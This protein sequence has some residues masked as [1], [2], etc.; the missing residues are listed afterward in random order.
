MV[1]VGGV[2]GGGWRG[3]RVVVEIWVVR[4]KG[5]KRVRGEV[6]LLFGDVRPVWI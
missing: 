3:R 6:S 2:D 5:E 1:I 4:W